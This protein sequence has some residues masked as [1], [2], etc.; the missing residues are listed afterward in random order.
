MTIKVVVA[1][2]CGLLATALPQPA[3]YSQAAQAPPSPSASDRRPPT[4]EHLGRGTVDDVAPQPVSPDVN[5]NARDR[6]QREPVT[7]EVADRDQDG[8]IDRREANGVPGLDF[9]RADSDGDAS[10]SRQEFQ[11]A[12]DKP[13]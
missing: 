1:G 2:M 13:R 5:S 10:L 12:I 8:K 7:F 6:E 4:Q 11:T 9:L 3:A